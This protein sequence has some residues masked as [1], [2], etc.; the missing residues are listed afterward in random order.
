MTQEALTIEIATLNDCPALAV[1]NQHL[2]EDEG[3]DNTM[4]LPELEER[5]RSWMQAGTYTGYLFK[6]QGETV[7]YA[8]VDLSDMWMRHFFISREHR[9]EGLGRRSVALLFAHLDTEEIGLSCLT[10]NAPGQA[11]W[12]SFGHEAHSTKFFIRRP[13][14]EASAPAPAQPGPAALIREVE[15]GDC[16]ALL[17]LY[18]ELGNHRATADNIA[19]HYARVQQDPRYKTF[20]AVVDGAIVGFVSSVQSLTVGYDPFMHITGLIVTA[21]MQHRGI[22]TQLLA[23]M[24]AYAKASGCSSVLL[25]SGV[26]RTGAHAFY[27][28]QGYGKHSWCFSKVF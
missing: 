17:P 2:I 23:R 22:G 13:D 11:F 26:Q 27:K 25:N 24:E 18:A 5:I 15:E 20:V 6:Q 10:H 21:D 4:T 14:G 19:E 7:G 3:A 12:Q 9:R 1:M 16:P 28:H 8:L